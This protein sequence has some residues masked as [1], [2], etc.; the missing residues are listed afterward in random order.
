MDIYSASA[1]EQDTVCCFLVFQ[2]IGELPRSTN[3]SVME[4]LVKGQLAQSE[5]HQA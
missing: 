1:E 3:Q 2:E 5:S 4:H